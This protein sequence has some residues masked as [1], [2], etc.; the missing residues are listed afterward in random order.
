MRQTAG[1]KGSDSAARVVCHDALVSS[2]LP[3]STWFPA[4]ARLVMG[5]EPR[6][7]ATSEAAGQGLEPRLPDPEIAPPLSRR[8]GLRGNRPQTSHFAGSAAFSVSG[9]VGS[10]GVPRVSPAPPSQ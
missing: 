6:F 5:D 1:T 10:Y 2:H 8:I 3:V 7:G 9:S 4:L